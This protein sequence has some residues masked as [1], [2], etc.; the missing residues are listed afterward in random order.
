M[1]GGGRLVSNFADARHAQGKQERSSLTLYSS[2]KKAAMLPSLRA[3]T[4]T[5]AMVRTAGSGGGGGG[6]GGCHVPPPLRQ[7]TRLKVSRGRFS[8]IEAPRRANEAPAEEKP[9]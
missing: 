4:S 9:N 3:S 8:A 1:F 7:R 2:S 6:G 5:A